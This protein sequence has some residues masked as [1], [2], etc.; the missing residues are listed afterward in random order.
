MNG[1]WQTC[2]ALATVAFVAAFWWK[3]GDP[4]YLE[5][6]SDETLKRFGARLVR[7]ENGKTY[8]EPPPPAKRLKLSLLLGLIL[9]I[10]YG[11]FLKFGVLGLFAQ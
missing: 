6:M 7:G 4:A 11:C 8:A 3:L 5:T 2:L 1:F 9:A 10:L